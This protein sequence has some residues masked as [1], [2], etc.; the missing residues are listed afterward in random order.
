MHISKVG[1]EFKCDCFDYICSHASSIFPINY[2]YDVFDLPSQF[3]VKNFYLSRKISPYI[4][5]M[6]LILL[7][8]GSTPYPADYQHILK[9]MQKIEIEDLIDSFN[10]DRLV[11]LF[12]DS[13]ELRELIHL[14]K[15]CILPPCESRF[16]LEEIAQFVESFLVN[17][18]SKYNHFSD[19]IIYTNSKNKSDIFN[20]NVNENNSN[21][22]SADEDDYLDDILIE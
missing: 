12:N 19:D 4:I 6:T 18:K 22:T 20:D 3:D 11:Y 2:L 15:R 14:W 7:L 1:I 9:C 21:Q 13:E 10:D 16:S 8:T 17:L 5:G